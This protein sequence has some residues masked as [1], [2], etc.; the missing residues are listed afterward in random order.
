VT[1]DDRACLALDLGGATT[2]VSLLGRVD[3]RWR[4]LG[5]T[6]APAATPVDALVATLVER[7]A[8]ADAALARD[9]D[10]AGVEGWPRLEARTGRPPRIVVL[11]ATERTLARLDA[12]ARRAGWAVT[13]A[14]AETTGPLEMTRLLLRRDVGTVLVGASDPPATDERSLIG[15][16]AELVAAAAGRR[17]EMTVVLSGGLADHA[18]RFG[19]ASSRPAF[20]PETAGDIQAGPSGEGPDVGRWASS[21]PA[22]GPETAGDI[23]AAGDAAGSGGRGDE[24]I[25]STPTM[26]LAPS[27]VA[28]EP[29][30]D[31]LRILLDELRCATDDGRR[32]IARA[33]GTLAAH[34]GRRVET[35]E[36]GQDG[37][38]RAVA[39]PAGATGRTGLRWA[40]VGEAAL[41]PD[42]VS[43]GVVEDVLGWSTLPL[44]RYRLR[45]RLAELRLTPWGEVQ[46][47]GAP[48][49]LAAARAALDRLV[50]LTPEL[51][52]PVPDLVVVAGGVWA[53]APGAAVALAVA[54]VLRRP[55]ASQ[56]ALDHARLLGPLGIVAD[57]ALRLA[58]VADLA[59][60]LLA[61]LGTV[62]IPAGLRAGRSAGDLV[63][64]SA[65]GTTE[66]E[67]VPGGLEL[68]DLPP[69]ESA[70]AEIRFRDAV[71]L[72][73]RGKHFTIDVAGG[74]GGL[75]I[76]LRD[77]PLHLP[78]RADRR[79]ELLAAWQRALWIGLEA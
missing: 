19:W 5:G 6:S 24:P 16:L 61:P 44:D 46:E 40:T 43:D 8:G 21:R 54:D 22:F 78:E 56:L 73:T 76:D 25:A 74:L 63:V 72:G 29:P 48:L 20:G 27:P 18:D 2:A 3:G 33:T 26:L 15:D 35:V 52:R 39:W 45:D 28:G 79:R 77:V 37:A 30:G 58:M 12:A 70:V 11:A 49:R 71:R 75:L 55:G 66:L 1:P 41:I 64:H 53:V 13:A 65:A 69:G 10:A 50:T 23:Q 4:F 31:A 68:V 47:D 9:L 62:V 17:P 14:C 60:D 34:L 32:A 38:L 42:P 57:D 67:L 7:L 59:G 51:D 36:I